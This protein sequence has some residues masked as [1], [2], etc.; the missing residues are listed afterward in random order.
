MRDLDTEIR[1]WRKRQEGT[2]SLTA[3]ELDELEDHLRA[4]AN[5]E[6]ELMAAPNP[7]RAFAL[8][9]DGLGEEPA[10]SREFARAGEPRWRKLMIAGW[11]MFG[12]SL[13]TP[14]LTFDLPAA[15]DRYY[16]YEVLRSHLSVSGFS[17]YALP[18]FIVL[19]TIPTLWNARYL[20]SRWLAGLLGG[21]V[22]VAGIVT[23]AFGFLFSLRPEVILAAVFGNPGFT[24]AVGSL[25]LGF[26][27]KASSFLPVAIALLLR[28]QHLKLLQPG[29]PISEPSE[30]AAQ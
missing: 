30:G 29:A 22:G 26:W 24:F 14:A 23:L 6:M 7:R 27:L 4:R 25:G 12:A 16:G 17:L 15:A 8:A 18:S 19:L 1:G 20:R 3:P 5:L 10:L 21:L 9:R 11:A 2:S 13:V 28:A